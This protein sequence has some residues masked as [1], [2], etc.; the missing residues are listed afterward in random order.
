MTD[1]TY[2]ASLE[3]GKIEKVRLPTLRQIPDYIVVAGHAYKLVG[4]AQTHLD[5]LDKG[6]ASGDAE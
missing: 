5:T 4:T 6:D 1:K 3:L 2:T